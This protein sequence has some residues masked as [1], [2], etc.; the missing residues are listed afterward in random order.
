M[1]AGE[2]VGPVDVETLA[3]LAREGELGPDTL[4]WTQGFAEWR[5]VRRVRALDGLMGPP[6]VP[7]AGEDGEARSEGPSGDA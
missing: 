7:A 5:P 1:A 6:P 4:V 3:R 2:P